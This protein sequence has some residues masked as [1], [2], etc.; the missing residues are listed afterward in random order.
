VATIPTATTGTKLTAAHYLFML[1]GAAGRKPCLIVHRSTTQSFT[2]SVE[3]TVLYNTVDRD[4]D[5]AYATGT[6]IFTCVTP[7]DYLFV[8]CHQWAASGAGGRFLHIVST[9]TITDAYTPLY[10]VGSPLTTAPCNLTLQT[11]LA[12]G[13]TV[14]VKAYQSS[15]VAL[16]TATTIVT[17]T[18]IFLGA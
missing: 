16:N 5:G 3:A 15:G 10:T 7:G 12:A 6:G 17:L 8:A 11:R 1:G 9:G 4:L 18:G 13:N 2:D 14:Q